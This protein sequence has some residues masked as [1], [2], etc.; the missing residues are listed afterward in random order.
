MNRVILALRT[1]LARLPY[2]RSE[3]RW[4]ARILLPP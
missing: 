3:E 4:P 2:F 1:F